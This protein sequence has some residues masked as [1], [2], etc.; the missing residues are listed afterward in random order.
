MPLEYW[1]KALIIGLTGIAGLSSIFL[2]HKATKP[3]HPVLDEKKFR[4]IAFII[5]SELP[6]KLEIIT[7]TVYNF[8]ERKRLSSK[9]VN[10]MKTLLI[11]K[12]ENLKIQ[13]KEVCSYFDADLNE[14]IDFFNKDENS[15]F[16]SRLHKGILKVLHPVF[17]FTPRFTAREYAK[18]L[19]IYIQIL[20]HYIE[21]QDYIEFIAQENELYDE[22]FRKYGMT[23]ELLMGAHYR[24]LSNIQVQHFLKKISELK[25][26]VKFDYKQ[27]P[28]S[29]A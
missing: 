5:S 1:H 27:I 13:V 15:T 14:F 25:K 10:S 8:K 24:F 19:K 7:Q 17:V 4:K 9:N 20:E 18:M 6:F 2:Y 3:S 22:I 12:A 21:K 29:N 16:V 11:Q 23:T 28:I 26:K